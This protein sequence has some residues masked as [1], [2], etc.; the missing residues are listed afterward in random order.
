[1]KFLCGISANFMTISAY[2]IMDKATKSHFECNLTCYNSH[3]LIEFI[4]PAKNIAED[5]FTKISKAMVITK[6]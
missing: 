2:F 1:M 5:K 3:L 4:K 6:T